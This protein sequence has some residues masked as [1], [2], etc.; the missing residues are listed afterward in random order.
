MG[1]VS[2]SRSSPLSTTVD[3]AGKVLALL[4]QQPNGLGINQLARELNTQRAPLGRILQSLIGH[5]L[6]RRDANK[7]YHLGVGTLE[8]ARAYSSRLPTGLESV[9]SALAD[10]T[11]MTAMLIDVVG[12]LMTT[13]LAKTPTTPEEHVFTPPGFRHPEGPLSMRVALEALQ[14]EQ[15]TDSDEVRDARARGFAVGLG[16]VMPGRYGAAMVVPGSA[17]GTAALV[18][19]LVSFRPFNPDEVAEPLHRA[20]QTIA[21]SA[22]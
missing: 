3:R 15:A 12:P 7:R 19:S 1:M 2:E 20:V 14:P 9:L 17:D 16:K 11:N 22:T 10:E 5:R 13:V 21:F 4:A 6:V 18:V 8:L